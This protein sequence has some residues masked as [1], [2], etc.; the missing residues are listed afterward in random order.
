[1]RKREK[2]AARRRMSKDKTKTNQGGHRA[3]LSL[4]LSVKLFVAFNWYERINDARSL[5]ARARS[6]W[7]MGEHPSELDICVYKGW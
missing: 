7:N 4:S 6:P 5:C 3:H 1:M 2:G